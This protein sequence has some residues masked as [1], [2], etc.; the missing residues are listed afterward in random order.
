M[1]V[2]S[3]DALRRSTDYLLGELLQTDDQLPSLHSYLWDRTRAVRKD[4]SFHSQKS[5]EEMKVMVYIL[6]TIAR[7]HVVSLHL[8]S[9]KGVASD[10]FDQQQEVQQL[11]ATLLS[12]NETYDDCRPRNI[13]CENEGEFR[14]LFLLLNKGDT[15]VVEKSLEWA[16]QPW[17]NSTHM[18]NAKSLLAA[19]QSFDQV[20]GPFNPRALGSHFAATAF[21]KFFDLVGS[22]TV[23]YTMACMCE[24]HFTW[25]R[26]RILQTLVKGFARRRDWPKDITPRI[27]NRMLRFDTEEEAVEFVK[28]HD[29][30]FETRQVDG[31]QE[32]FLL[33][34]SKRQHV[35]SP[36]VLQSHSATIVEAKRNGQPLAEV[37]RK[38]V[39][40]DKDIEFNDGEPDRSHVM[41]DSAGNVDSDDGDDMFVGQSSRK[42]AEPTTDINGSQPQAHQATPAFG[43]PSASPFA[44]KPSPF[45]GLTNPFGAPSSANASPFAPTDAKSTASQPPNGILSNGTTATPAPPSTPAASPFLQGSGQPSTAF[46][47]TAQQSATDNGT[48]N[49]MSQP[50]KA[51]ETSAFSFLGAAQNKPQAPATGASVFA[52]LSKTSSPFAGFPAGSSQASTPTAATPSAVNKDTSTMDAKTATPQSSIFSGL[53]SEKSTP[54]SGSF[55]PTSTPAVSSSSGAQASNTS[56][57]PATSIFSAAG[58]I[59]I[60][61]ATSAAPSTVSVFAQPPA[62]TSSTASVPD[63]QPTQLKPVSPRTQNAQTHAEPTPPT[64]ATMPPSAAPPPASDPMADFTEWFVKGDGG[65]LAEFTEFTVEDIL[66]DTY[67]QWLAENAERQRREEDEASWA[68][69]RKHM[70]Y[71]LGVKFFYRWRE[72]ARERATRRILREGKAKYKAAMEERARAKREKQQA[73]ERKKRDE[74]RQREERLRNFTAADELEKIVAEHHRSRQSS[75]EEALLASGVFAGIRNERQVARRVVREAYLPVKKRP[76]ASSRSSSI[77]MPPP[78]ETPVKKEGWKTRSLREKLHL[79][80]RR[81]SF[82]SA[83]VAGTGASN[84]SQSLPVGGGRIAKP[85]KVTNFSASTSSRKR[86]ADT[87]DDEPEAKKGKVLKSGL[88]LHWELRRR[89]LVQ[90]PDGHW[91]PQRI[92]TQMFEGKRFPGYGDCGLGPAATV[93]I[94]DIPAAAEKHDRDNNSSTTKAKPSDASAR[95]SKLEALARRFG[96][97][98]TK[99]YRRDSI[100]SGSSYNATSLLSS[101]PGGNGKRKRGA[102]DDA[103]S[104]TS[105]K[106][107][108]VDSTSDESGGEDLTPA[109]KVEKALNKMRRQIRELNEDMDVLESEDTPWMR[110]EMERMTGTPGKGSA[111][112]VVRDEASF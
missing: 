41:L 11:G 95:E 73:A 23:S 63:S 15:A 26:Q 42:T 53:A 55:F 71:R 86:S 60:D 84:F 35:P 74:E 28:L 110:R 109:K 107:Y 88:S 100:A 33:L 92:A 87:S 46:T 14:A 70:A 108:V 56:T 111:G 24:I 69:A 64:P 79:S 40:G 10:D 57:A 76:S 27:L 102:D 16:S 93:H 103:G 66:M 49:P 8:L 58:T 51:P 48:A 25:V 34:K 5:S 45:A 67:Q 18:E 17:Y 3:F 81:D 13:V 29:F 4:F 72:T 1:D 91:L 6:E 32:Q 54:P 20:T 62:T 80:K 98:P 77:S 21:T 94:D 2:R 19:L 83:S 90:M 75:A 9:R 38:S 30:E 44:A 47:P 89:G 106:A 22:K 96:F 61:K 82:S 78:A 52:D 97:P 43:A 65:L 85:P 68:A 7:F 104:P 36:R 37:F 12:L 50:P 112:G 101:S 99:T 39:Y 59:G 105:K 31:R